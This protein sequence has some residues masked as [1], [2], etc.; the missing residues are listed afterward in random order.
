MKTITKDLLSITNG[1]ICHQV[2]CQGVMGSG[3]ALAI[4][5]KWPEVFDTYRRI[6]SF[7]PPTKL[8]GSCQL[9]QV[10]PDLLVANIFGQNYFGN[11]FGPAT[12]YNA[13][14]KAFTDLR[15]S[16]SNQSFNPSIYIPYKMGC[17]L[18]GGNWDTYLEIVT[19]LFPD[20]IVCQR[21]EDK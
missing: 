14:E 10:G 16:L 6:W 5:K 4:R 11:Q 3:I 20:V 15:D 7:T 18:G 19:K 9:I 8:L 1:I 21:E 13:V 12:D 2:N 17:G